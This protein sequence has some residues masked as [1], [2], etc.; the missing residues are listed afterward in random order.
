MCR[1]RKA[2][3]LQIPVT[4]LEVILFLHEQELF[5]LAHLGVQRPIYL[6]Y[7]S[8]DFLIFFFWGGENS[9]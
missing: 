9:L 7:H 1:T 6:L 4:L 5:R 8:T 2:Q 3:D